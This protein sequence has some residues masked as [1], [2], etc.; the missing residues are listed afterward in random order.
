VLSAIVCSPTFY[1]SCSRRQLLTILLNGYE[2]G[3][4]HC[5]LKLDKRDKR[6]SYDLLAQAAMEE[7]MGEVLMAVVSSS[8]S[9]VIGEV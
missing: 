8:D 1:H 6:S 5:P 2:S 9:I 7:D 3:L 4:H